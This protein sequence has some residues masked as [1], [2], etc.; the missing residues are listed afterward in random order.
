MMAFDPPRD[1]MPPDP[2]VR[3]DELVTK[4]YV[5]EK[6]T[7]EAAVVDLVREE[8]FCRVMAGDAWDIDSAFGRCKD[9]ANM[10]NGITDLQTRLE[11]YETALKRI[12]SMTDIE[13]D[14]DGFEALDIARKALGDSH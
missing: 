10:F 14:F 9:I 12:G 7:N 13:A 11:R 5:A 8:V 3:D 1:A 4:R 2:T 6:R